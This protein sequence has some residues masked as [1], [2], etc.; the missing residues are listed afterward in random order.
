M[1]W[2]LAAVTTCLQ[3]VDHPPLPCPDR[4]VAAKR[5]HVAH[6]RV[7]NTTR[8]AGNIDPSVPTHVNYAFAKIQPDGQVVH[9]EQNE[10]QLIA[11]LQVRRCRLQ[12]AAACL[13]LLRRSLSVPVASQSVDTCFLD[14]MCSASCTLDLTGWFL[15]TCTFS[16]TLWSGCSLSCGLA[17]MTAR[18]TRVHDRL[19][20]RP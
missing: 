6:S 16:V 19:P 14:L 2:W 7:C 5:R 4:T 10:P 18:H 17:S 11:Q 15:L 9:V 3:G 20:C 12:P 8:S 13:P 1:P